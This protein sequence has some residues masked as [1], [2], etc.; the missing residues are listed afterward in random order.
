MCR[1]LCGSFPG[2]NQ[3]AVRGPGLV[4]LNISEVACPTSAASELAAS[5]TRDDPGGD[6]EHVGRRKTVPPA[7]AARI[8]G[9]TSA[10]SARIAPTARSAMITNRS[11]VSSVTAPGS[12][13]AGTEN[14][15]T[16]PERTAVED[17][18]TVASMSCG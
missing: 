2:R 4:A 15:T 10:G 3:V 16:N 11:P 7:I 14:A 6:H 5:G 8:A 1:W 17:S 13:L 12:S 9:V 18:E